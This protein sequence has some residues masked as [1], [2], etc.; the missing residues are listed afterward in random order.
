VSDAPLDDKFPAMADDGRDREQ[1]DS[2]EGFLKAAIRTYWEQGAKS[3]VNFLAL[4]FA[5]K[6]AW[7]VAWGKVATPDGGKKVLTGAAGAAALTLILRTVVGGPIGILLTGASIASLVAIYVKNHKRIW[8]KVDRYKVVID[9]YRTAYEE[10]R[11][12][13]TEGGLKDSQ[14]DLMVD[15]LLGR[16]LVELDSYEPNDAV[17]EEEE[18]DEKHSFAAHTEKKR[19]EIEREKAR[20]K[21]PNGEDESADD[22]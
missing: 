3:K 19:A 17:D 6:E 1:Y 14:R 7:Q 5:S 10:V 2:Y 9:E 11:S 12:D 15:G 16:F 13:W 22:E 4:L 21:A 20:A 18:D 8:L